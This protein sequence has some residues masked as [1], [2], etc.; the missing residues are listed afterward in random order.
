MAAAVILAAAFA[1]YAGISMVQAPGNAGG[2]AAH[3]D[4]PE[5]QRI[6]TELP[7]GAERSS[8]GVTFR[9]IATYR[10][11]SGRLCREYT[12]ASNAQGADAVACKGDDG[13]RLAL[14][15]SE[16]AKD[17]RYVPAGADDIISTYLE[18]AQAGAPL[19]GDAERA[20]L[21]ARL[22]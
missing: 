8:D 19:T 21:H 13:W 3:L 15:S 18:R 12:V 22:Q 9:A 11:G 5:A 4:G 7:S 10:L 2:L 1:G 17:D 16:G 6:L 14:A 20:A